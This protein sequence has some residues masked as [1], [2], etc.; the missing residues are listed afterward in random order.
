MA[1]GDD[2]KIDG[3]R[4]YYES[5][6]TGRPLLC[7]HPVTI[8]GRSWRDFASEMSSSY[9]VLV[10][11]LPGH[12][13]SDLWPTWSWKAQKI[14]LEYYGEVLIKLLDILKID[15]VSLMGCAMG[16]NIALFL[17]TRLKE[18]AKCVVSYGGA[19]KTSTFTQD[20]LQTH[21]SQGRMYDIGFTMTRV[22][23]NT[24]RRIIENINW[25]QN[26]SCINEVSIADT[27]AWNSFDILAEL[28]AI[29]SPVLL[30]RGQDDLIVT[31]NMLDMTADKIKTCE[32][33]ELK[34][35]GAWPMLED[36]PAL[37]KAV[38]PFLQR[39]S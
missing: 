27:L 2:V 37:V 17:A 6:G 20:Q 24:P 35:I 30:M 14:S 22:G 3:A 19:G 28:S 23:G 34:G 16:A 5:S 10:P 1:R 7:I 13:K 4:V 33:M 9:T 15:S 18:R 26:S 8:D 29:R 31:K 39:Y 25:L 32:I 21:L 36:T 11:D 12:G 38:S